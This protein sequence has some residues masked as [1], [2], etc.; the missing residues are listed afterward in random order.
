[1][2][3]ILS[4]FFT[5]FFSDKAE[6]DERAYNS[7]SGFVIALESGAK[8][9]VATGEFTMTSLSRKGE[10]IPL[11]EPIFFEEKLLSAPEIQFT[12]GDNADGS[13]GVTIGNL[14]Y[15]LTGLMVE[16]SRVLDGA[17]ITT[18]VCLRKTDG[19]YE[20]LIYAYG[21]L[22]V[23]GGDSDEAKIEFVSDMSDRNVTA[24]GLEITQKCLNE[25][26]VITGLSFCPA[27]NLPEGANCSKIKDDKEAGCGYWGQEAFFKGI[28]FYNPNTLP[29]Y[30]SISGVGGGA[31]GGL[32]GGGDYGGWQEPLYLGGGDCPDADSFFKTPK[33]WKRGRDL[34]EGDALIDHLDRI[35]LIEKIEIVQSNFRYLIES[36]SGA[37]GIFSANHPV[38]TSFDDEKGTALYALLP[39]DKPTDARQKVL[40][41]QELLGIFNPKDENDDLKIIEFA[42]GASRLTKFSYRIAKAGEVLKISLTAPHIYIAGLTSGA[43]FAGHNL[44]PMYSRLEVWQVAQ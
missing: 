8:I 9:N 34:R 40:K 18:Y 25:L 6:L 19:T 7:H 43:G 3:R 14:D 16:S 5:Q 42:G 28:A 39:S 4:S 29:N 15:L 17:K 30:P 20:G 31:G 13:T 44:K 27:P 11:A 22:R 36:P 10:S 21:N 2:A 26:G 35:A 24:G 32:I 1:M 12:Q 38:I 23:S 37:K 33:G 41:R